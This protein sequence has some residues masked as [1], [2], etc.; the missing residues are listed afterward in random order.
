MCL[1]LAVRDT[2]PK[3]AANYQ[4]RQ[5]TLTSRLYI[6]VHTSG[7]PGI[8]PHK[9]TYNMTERERGGKG[10]RDRMGGERRGRRLG[11]KESQVQR[12][13]V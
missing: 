4:G 2:V 5:S 3:P 6:E 9:Y 10:G 13:I 1:R 12:N 8:H 7:Y 11:S